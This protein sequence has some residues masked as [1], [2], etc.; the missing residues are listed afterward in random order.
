MTCS[1]VTDLISL[2][3]FLPQ[4]LEKKL[5]SRFSLVAWLPPQPSMPL[6]V[7]SLPQ[8]ASLY[9]QISVYMSYFLRTCIIQNRLYI[10]IQINRHLYWGLHFLNWDAITHIFL[11][12]DFSP[13]RLCLMELSP[14]Q[15]DGSDL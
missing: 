4:G 3:P 2:V 11:H 9:P 5:L 1:Q 10:Y 8:Q 7:I 6:A 14:S 12:L 15:G 13:T